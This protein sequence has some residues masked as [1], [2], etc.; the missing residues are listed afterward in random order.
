MNRILDVQVLKYSSFRK[1]E[2]YVCLRYGV[3]FGMEGGEKNDVFQLAHV[4]GPRVEFQR[5]DCRC[6]EVLSRL[7][8][9]GG[10]AFEEEVGD[11]WDVL[12]GFFQR[13]N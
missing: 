5:L 10:I 12:G 3:T 6:V 8:C 7:A 13:R 11:F 2:S 4:A 9:L 1:I